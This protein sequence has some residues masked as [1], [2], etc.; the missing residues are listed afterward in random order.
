MRQLI[1]SITFIA[2]TINCFSQD[3]MDAIVE[4]SCNCVEKVPDTLETEQFNIRLGVC[5]I[6]ASMKYKKEIKRDYGI[7]MDKVDTEGEKLGRIIGIK[8]ASKCPSI[9]LKLS[10]K[11][12]KTDNGNNEKTSSGT[13]IKIDE[14]CFVIISLQDESGKIT[15]FYWMT[16]I[17]TPIDL[18]NSYST[19]MGKSL[20]ITSKSQEFFDPK[21]KEYRQ[22]S[23]IKKIEYLSK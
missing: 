11:S 10:Q 20:T 21:L 4:K 14:D 2:L 7:N 22:F 18:T 12:K 1:I 15:K 8:M 13:V 6:E 9:L 17:T 5:M 23:V 3:Y 19:L 16:F